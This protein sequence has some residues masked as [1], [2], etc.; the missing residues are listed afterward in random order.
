MRVFAR[1]CR[2]TVGADPIY[3]RSASAV[4]F[5]SRLLHIIGDVPTS[6]ARAALLRRVLAVFGLA[7]IASTWPLW[8]PQHVFPQV[9]LLRIGAVVPAAAQW[10]GAASMIGGLLAALVGPG[11]CWRAGLLVFATAALGMVL[12][13]VERLQPWCY[14][15]T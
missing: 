1:I 14:S 13:D 7:L 2:K 5:I 4:I 11:R 15:N 3:Q 6:V 8:T 9:P 10:F 12:T